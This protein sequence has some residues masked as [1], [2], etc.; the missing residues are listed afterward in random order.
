MQ[1]W[2]ELPHNQTIPSC[3]STND[4]ARDLVRAGAPSGTWISADSQTEG[5]GR[6]KRSWNSTGENLYISMICKTENLPLAGWMPLRLGMSAH[7]ALLEFFPALE[8]KLKWPNDLMIRSEGG[9]YKKLGGILCEGATNGSTLELVCGIGI[10]C[11]T[12]SPELAGI[13]GFVGI[14][15]DDLR[16]RL[17]SHWQAEISNQSPRVE[18]LSKQYEKAIIWKL[19]DP[20]FF[21]TVREGVL[22]EKQKA[23][24]LGIH[25]DGGLKVLTESGEERI[26]YSDEVSLR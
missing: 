11:T 16:E 20:L 18:Y 9:A 19:G 3:T 14:P 21:S 17:I 15:V 8:I 12:P 24:F 10:N 6:M 2:R 5:R 13:A 7:A 22:E 26:L 23:K 1:N 25:L 4:L